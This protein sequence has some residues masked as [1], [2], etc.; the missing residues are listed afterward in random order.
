MTEQLV[1]PPQDVEN[2]AKFFQRAEIFSELDQLKTRISYDQ[3]KVSHQ[4][5]ERDSGERHF[6]HARSVALILYDECGLQTPDFF[7]G[8]VLHDTG[9]DNTLWGS[10]QGLTYSQ[11][12]NEARARMN[13]TY[14]PLGVADPVLDVTKPKIDG[15]EIKDESEVLPA[16]VEQLR[17][18]GPKGKVLKLAD[19]LHNSRTLGYRKTHKQTEVAHKNLESYLPVLVDGRGQYEAATDWMIDEI[20]EINN[21]Y[22]NGTAH[23]LRPNQNLAGVNVVEIGSAKKDG[24]GVIFSE[25]STDDVIGGLTDKVF[26]RI[27]GSKECRWVTVDEMSEE[28]YSELKKSG[29]P[30][31]DRKPTQKP[32]LPEERLPRGV[33]TASQIRDELLKG[34]VT[35]ALAATSIQKIFEKEGLEPEEAY[36]RIISQHQYFSD[37]T[38]PLPQ[39]QGVRWDN[40]VI[41][42]GQSLGISE[43]QRIRERL[44]SVGTQSERLDLED[45]AF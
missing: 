19:I 41:C 40:F 6:E 32:V 17:K 10:M 22:L 7:I 3:A 13:H 28:V 18:A 21:A 30:L 29:V 38:E 31:V 2:R 27:P 42:M 16:Y 43:E 4:H 37:A 35:P 5:Q 23:L 12:V 24:D 44:V 34:R 45:L 9:E 36:L 20:I 1:P 15:I 26:M 33:V 25:P 39:L 11:W 8:G 14:A